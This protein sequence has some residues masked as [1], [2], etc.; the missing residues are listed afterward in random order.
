MLEVTADSSAALRRA[1]ATGASAARYVS[2]TGCVLICG[3]VSC[4]QAAT[5]HEVR[6][7][8]AARRKSCR[9]RSSSAVSSYGTFRRHRPTP[10]WL[11]TAAN[12]NRSFGYGAASKPIFIRTPSR[13]LQEVA[14][15][16]RGMQKWATRSA[17]SEP[18]KTTTNFSC[19]HTTTTISGTTSWAVRHTSVPRSAQLV[20]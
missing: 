20:C 1:A 12:T 19:R 6:Q 14:Q 13:T 9:F 10:G 18:Q 2:T 7:L 11:W 8:W 16:G 4:R 5:M 17:F 15:S 3:P